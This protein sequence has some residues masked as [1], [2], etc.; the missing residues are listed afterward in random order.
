MALRVLFINPE[1]ALGGAERCL[2]DL[3][4]SFADRPELEVAPAALLLAPGPLVD[5]LRKAGVPT[6]VF[7]LPEFWAGLGEKGQP[8]LWKRP[9]FIVA[10]L[11]ELWR[12]SQALKQRAADLLPDVIHSNGIK[13]HLLWGLATLRTPLANGNGNVPVIWHVHD[14][15]TSRRFS[16]ALLRWFSRKAY[17][18]VANSTATLER[19]QSVLRCSLLR[20]YNGVAESPPSIKRPVELAKCRIGLVATYARWKGHDLFFE[21][22]AKLKKQKNS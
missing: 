13:T 6:E 5:R 4:I 9:W 14:F 7:P 19:A 12:W 3:A 17:A 8:G 22:I 16:R 18:A 11:V 21:A 15:L 10:Q 2:E 1:A 20:I